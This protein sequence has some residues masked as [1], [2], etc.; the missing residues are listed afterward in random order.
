[1]FSM[2]LTSVLLLWSVASGGTMVQAFKQKN[3][4]LQSNSGWIEEF[5]G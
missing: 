1:M 3:Y 4:T 5:I 2:F